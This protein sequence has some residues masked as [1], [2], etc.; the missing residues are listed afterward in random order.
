[1]LKA[2]QVS[3]G[4]FPFLVGLI[5]I[6]IVDAY[7]Q[8]LRSAGRGQASF[9]VPPNYVISASK[10]HFPFTAV[11]I[12]LQKNFHFWIGR[13]DC[14]FRSLGICSVVRDLIDLSIDEMRRY[15]HT[16]LEKQGR[17]LLGLHWVPIPYFTLL[18]CLA[19]SALAIQGQRQNGH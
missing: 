6:W 16:A 5:R 17:I 10:F 3:Y 13:A 11:S 1:M 9:F 2:F 19:D 14:F 7:Y 4:R 12:S 18:Q 15:I 8:L